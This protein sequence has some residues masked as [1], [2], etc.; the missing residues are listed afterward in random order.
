VIRLG[1]FLL[2]IAIDTTISAFTAILGGIF[3][4]YSRFNTGVTR[5]WAR[6]ILL[7]AGVKLHIEG[8]EHLQEGESYVVVSN[9]QSLMDIPV[10]L[11]GLPVPLRI[12]AKQELFRIPIFG[13]GM[14]GV[15]MLQIDR[16]NQK[17]SFETLKKAEQIIRRHHL[18]ILA[19]PEGTRSEDGKIHPFKK[20]PF[21][22]AINTGLSLLPVSVS[23]TR[24]IIPK[25]KIQVNPG[26]VKV[27]IHSPI[28]VAGEEF[29]RRNELVTKTQKII[30]QGF[31]EAY[32]QC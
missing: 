16:S 25:G 5:I 23:G 22:L 15:G 2:I 18:S 7:A 4:P 11:Y 12:I 27:K 8:T 26:R 17:Q 19:F 14:K 31:I 9:H 13:W 6:I 10:L 1:L 3:N 28:P 30:E 21:I 29:S 24:Q 32:K 20:G